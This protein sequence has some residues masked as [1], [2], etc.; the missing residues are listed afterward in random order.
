MVEVTTDLPAIS[1]TPPKCENAEIGGQYE[2]EDTTVVCRIRKRL[3]K[4]P[5]V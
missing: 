3:K 2:H 4:K 5:S 1:Q